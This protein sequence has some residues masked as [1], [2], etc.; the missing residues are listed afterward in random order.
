MPL[1]SRWAELLVSVKDRLQRFE[2]L[3]LLL[4]RLCLGLEFFESGK[5]K[6]FYGLDGLIDSFREWGIPLP[7]V[8]APFVATVEF[9]GGICL[10]LGLGTRVFSALLAGVM[11]VALLTI[12]TQENVTSLAHDT[13]GNFLYLPEVGF[14][15]LFIAKVLKCQNQPEAESVS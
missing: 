15:L 4:V 14:L 9:V 8:Q 2:W 7:Q 3:P 1:P 12:M 10:I 13:L 5:G 11:A 6:L